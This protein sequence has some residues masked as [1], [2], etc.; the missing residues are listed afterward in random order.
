MAV[1]T[2][3]VCRLCP[4]YSCCP[5]RAFCGRLCNTVMEAL[6]L[7]MCLLFPAWSLRWG[8]SRGRLPCSSCALERQV[9]V[10]LCTE[11]RC[12]LGFWIEC[13]SNY[14]LL[15]RGLPVTDE[16]KIK[17]RR[18]I[19]QRVLFSECESVHQRTMFQYHTLTQAYVS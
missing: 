2:R 11:L 12:G 13:L 7:P 16:F 10:Q 9:S 1:G 18:A 17:V 19:P 5:A 3:A 6:L 8:R 4:F 14:A 15:C